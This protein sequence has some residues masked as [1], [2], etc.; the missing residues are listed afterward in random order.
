MAGNGLR[1]R[2]RLRKRYGSNSVALAP[3]TASSRCIWWYGIRIFVPAWRVL[4]PSTVVDST[5]R[6]PIGELESR[7]TSS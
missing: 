6:A 7:R 1:A 2:S 3:K 5:V 4:P